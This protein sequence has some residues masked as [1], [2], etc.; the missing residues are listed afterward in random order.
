MATIKVETIVTGDIEAHV[1][2][3]LRQPIRLRSDGSGGK[4]SVDP[5]TVVD[6]ILNIQFVGQ[7]GLGT[8][9]TLKVNQLEPNS[10]VLF[11]HSGTIGPSGITMLT[12]AV[13]V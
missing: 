10:R 13:S 9:W 11:D 7:G 1:V 4:R 3:E 8:D 2:Y 5:I 12:N 6:G